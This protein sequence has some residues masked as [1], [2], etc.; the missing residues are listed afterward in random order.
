MED[1][2]GWEGKDWRWRRWWGTF[3]SIVW[4][5]WWWVITTSTTTSSSTSPLTSVAFLLHLLIHGCACVISLLHWYP[6]ASYSGDSSL[7]ASHVYYLST[8]LRSTSCFSTLASCFSTY[9]AHHTALR[10]SLF[11]HF[12]VPLSIIG[13]ILHWIIS[14]HACLYVCCVL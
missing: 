9:V 1:H 12:I 6:C 11:Q 8:Q 7:M 13:H 2:W 4:Q 10:T 14:L 3:Y 5:L